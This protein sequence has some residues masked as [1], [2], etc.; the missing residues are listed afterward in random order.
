MNYHFTI[1][2]CNWSTELKSSHSYQAV[3]PQ[4]LASTCSL[5]MEGDYKNFLL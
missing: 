5:D 3:F 1:S 2:Q 4:S